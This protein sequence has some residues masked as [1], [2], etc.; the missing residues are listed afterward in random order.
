M[1][2]MEAINKALNGQFP[3]FLMSNICNRSMEVNK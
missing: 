3:K 2:S 1:G